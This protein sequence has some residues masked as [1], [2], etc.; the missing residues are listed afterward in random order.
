MKQDYTQLI[1][2][3]S[4]QKENFPLDQQFYTDPSIYDIDLE[5]FFYNQWI[6]V[7]HESQ[8]KNNGDYFLFEIGNESIIIIRDKNSN[9]N[10]FYN[11]CRHRGSHICIEKEGKTKKLVCP[12]HAWAYDLEGNL[13]SARM[14]DEKFNKKDWNLNKCSSKVYEGLIFIN[15]SENSDDFNKFINPVKDFIELHGLN[16]SKIAFKK[17]YPT[18]GNWKLTLDNFHECYHCLPAHPE[19]CQVHSKEYIQAYGAGNNTGP[20]SIEFSNQLKEWNKKTENLG[21]LKGEFSDEG[22]SNFFRSAERTPFDGDRLSETKD[23]KPGSIL[24]GKFKEFDGGYTTVGTSPFNSLI[25]SNDFATTFTFI[26]RGP[27]ETD[28]EIMWLVHE[29]AI[30]GK[31]YDLNNLIWMWDQTT[32][33]DKKI[34]EN[35]QKGVMSKKYIPG[36]L[37]EMEL[38]LKK[39]KKWYLTHLKNKISS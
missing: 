37:S 14:M 35:N 29:D 18:S 1:E 17:T 9:I 26:P 22:F 24:M 8:I 23:G 13:I 15:L 32:I 30:E 10:C 31:D 12:Y 16:K 25:M 3:I 5:T 21:Y 6:F 27:M 19:Y 34:I 36:P 39:L 4:N 11:V 2:L 33:A 28:V 20:E 7:G 38:G